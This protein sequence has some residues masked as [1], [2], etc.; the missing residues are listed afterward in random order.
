MGAGNGLLPEHCTLHTVAG[1]TMVQVHR[2][3]M[4]KLFL[5]FSP[6]LFPPRFAPCCLAR[7]NSCRTWLHPTP[8]VYT[9]Q[10]MQA[11]ARARTRT[12]RTCLIEITHPQ[13]STSLPPSFSLYPLLLLPAPIIIGPSHTSTQAYKHTSTHTQR[14]PSKCKAKPCHGPFSTSCSPA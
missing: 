3:R 6:F 8:Y 7:S 13:Q 9:E 12:G 11:S 5:S 1:T 14:D 2:T 4:R 10:A